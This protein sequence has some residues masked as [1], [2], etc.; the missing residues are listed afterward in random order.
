M[1]EKPFQNLL[2]LNNY[3][4]LLFMSLWLT[5]RKTSDLEKLGF[6]WTYICGQLADW[7]GLADLGELSSMWLFIFLKVSLGLFTWRLQVSELVTKVCKASWELDLEL[8]RCQL[9]TD[10]CPSEAKLHIQAEFY[11]KEKST[12]TITQLISSC[13]VSVPG[14]HVFLLLLGKLLIHPSSPSSS[15]ICG[16]P[17]LALP[18]QSE[19]CWTRLLL[20]AYGFSALRTDAVF[21]PSLYLRCLAQYLAQ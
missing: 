8:T 15:I 3:H 7:L 4:L 6:T 10:A 17:P 20:S 5:K 11:S 13:M 12:N 18:Q 16:K 21:Q 14:R 2:A 19:H 1:H 9:T